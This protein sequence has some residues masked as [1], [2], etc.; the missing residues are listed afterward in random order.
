M[1]N[2]SKAWMKLWHSWWTSRSH[3]HLSM[4]QLGIGAFWLSLA[5]ARDY[6]E[7]GI[8]WL[9]KGSGRPLT[10]SELASMTT[11]ADA[12][13]CADLLVE[14]VDC[15]TMVERNGRFGFANMARWQ[16]SPSASR[17]RA[18]RARK[19]D[20]AERY[21][22]ASG[23]ASVTARG[24]RKEDRDQDPL[25]KTRGEDRAREAPPAEL[26]PGRLPDSPSGASV[27]VRAPVREEA[28]RIDA[29]ARARTRASSVPI[30]APTPSQ[31]PQKGNGA[32]PSP[33][34]I[35]EAWSDAGL[36]A[37]QRN[38]VELLLDRA[39]RLKPDRTLEWCR[40]YFA[41]IAASPWCRGE[42]HSHPG[43]R[44]WTLDYALGSEKRIADVLAGKFDE[45]I[46]S[47]RGIVS[48]R[49]GKQFSI[50]GLPEED[51]ARML[52]VNPKGE[53]NGSS[54][55]NATVERAALGAGERQS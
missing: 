11:G 38:E 45:R 19:R 26:R 8:G 10:L 34:A 22:N 33:E 14:L 6:D 46:A 27:E 29:G 39:V 3:A 42:V 5:N 48:A 24:K 49:P 50:L 36:P 51:L 15:G 20:E 53:R 41:R 1:G 21:S 9:V 35:L 18:H 43:S 7:E 12:S 2:G 28:P 52:G 25:S 32:P 16:E 54:R 47:E 13:M 55:V 23:N 37:A 17:V 4:V 30:V 44:A 31:A 40:S